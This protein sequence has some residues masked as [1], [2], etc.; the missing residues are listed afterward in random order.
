MRA[1]SG[2]TKKGLLDGLCAGIGFHRTC[3]HRAWFYAVRPAERVSHFR[4]LIA[5]SDWRFVPHSKVKALHEAP[6]Q[7]PAQ[8]DERVGSG[9]F[10]RGG[11]AQR[12]T[13]TGCRMA[14][15]TAG[16][17]QK[18]A[19]MRHHGF[20]STDRSHRRLHCRIQ[21]DSAGSGRGVSQSITG[22][23]RRRLRLWNHR[24]QQ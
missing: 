21:T 11:A 1:F 10:A 23:R 2:Q 22:F 20:K 5:Y 12:I 16:S 8:R 4:D 18:N 6:R 15:P 17:R 13:L 7:R 9:T 14:K 24:E 19:S 3:F